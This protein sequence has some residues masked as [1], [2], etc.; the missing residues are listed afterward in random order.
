MAKNGKIILK[1]GRPHWVEQGVQTEHRVHKIPSENKMIPISML[2]REMKELLSDA[3]KFIHRKDFY[4]RADFL[5]IYQ[6]FHLLTGNKY[7]DMGFEKFKVA[8]HQAR[9]RGY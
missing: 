9:K 1:D 5:S 2:T 6:E 3:H 7:L 4:E 8:C